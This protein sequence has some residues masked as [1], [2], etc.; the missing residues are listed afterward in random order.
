MWH[1]AVVIVY[2]M[3]KGWELVVVAIEEW[4]PL[5]FILFQECKLPTHAKAFMFR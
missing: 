2:Y 4:K 5:Y 3:R 1:I